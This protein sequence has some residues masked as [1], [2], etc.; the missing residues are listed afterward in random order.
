MKKIIVISLFILSFLGCKKASNDEPIIAEK[1]TIITPLEGQLKAA[2][3]VD[4]QWNKLEGHGKII[5][6]NLYINDS[7]YTSTTNTYY[8][9]YT[10]KVKYH[11]IRIEAVTQDEQIIKGNEISFGISKKGLATEDNF[12]ALKYDPIAMNVSWYY[13]WGRGEFDTI[14][15]H[16]YEKI[17]YVPMIWNATNSTEVNKKIND[18]I[19]NKYKNLL[20]YNEPDLTEQANMSVEQAL[21]FWPNLQS[22]QY[23]LSSPATAYWPSI[24]PTWFQPFMQEIA[25]RNYQLDFITIHAYPENFEGKDLANWFI[26]NII[27]PTYETYHKPIWITEFSTI[28]NAVTKE[29]TAE[30]LEYVMPMLDELEY[31]ERYSY[32]SYDAGNCNYGLI[33]FT[34]GELSPAGEVYKNLGNPK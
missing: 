23:R 6:Y 1:L 8:E 29:G 21:S 10:T 33:D 19:N 3:Y 18:V 34:T 5:S 11:K 13:N 15:H 9:Y 31:V 12:G 4:I 27:K 25:N 14:N 28:G 30:F 22:H 7:L 26:E 2:G 32:F 17:E 16:G 24:S 20:T